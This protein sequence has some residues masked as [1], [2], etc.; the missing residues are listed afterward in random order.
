[1]TDVVDDGGPFT[2]ATSP[3]TRKKLRSD[4]PDHVFAKHEFETPIRILFSQTPKAGTDFNVSANV[5]Q[6]ILTMLKADSTLSVLSLDKKLTYHPLHNDFPASE[7]NFK[8]YFLVHPA[9]TKP[10]K[11]QSVMVGCILCS[12]K[13][14]KT[15]KFDKIEPSPVIDWLRSHKIFI[16]ADALGH[17]VTRVVGHLL[18]IHPKITH[19]LYL[20]D[21]LEDD[22]QR[23]KITPQEV[24]ALDG[25]AQA[26]YQQTMDSG[27]DITTFVPPFELFPTDL[28]S[29]PADNRVSTIA[30][31]IKTKASHHNL[32]RELFSQLFTQ[33]PSDLAHV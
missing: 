24:I 17:E 19:Q 33:P 31:G 13:M 26:H 22:L 20:Q 30:I 28:G 1:M 25:S 9:S 27:D 15:I 3:Q 4:E 6:V 10:V 29:G 12:S 23:V 5:K 2:P 16:E 21:T 7:E 8:T 11:H 14:V 32:L 18:R